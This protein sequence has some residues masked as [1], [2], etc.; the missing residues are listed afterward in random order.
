MNKKILLQVITYIEEHIFEEIT[1]EKLS[2]V[3]HY[4]QFY[5]A[6]L[7]KAAFRENISD[8]QKKRRLTIAAQKLL[9]T[10]MRIID[11]AILCG[12]Q[13]Q[14]AFT[15]SFKKYFDVTP[16]HYRKKKVPFYNLYKYPIT[17]QYI[18]KLP[19]A[20]KE[21]PYT[22]IHLQEFEI[23][24]LHYQGKNEKHEVARLYNLV[25]AALHFEV[26]Y[27]KIDG[28]YGLEYVGSGEYEKEG[29]EILVGVKKEY[30]QSTEIPIGE[31]LNKKVLEADYAVFELT[32]FI[33][34]IRSQVELIWL[35]MLQD[36][37]YCC[38]GNYCFEFYEQGF[39]PN[40]DGKGA[41][42]YLPVKR[43]QD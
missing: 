31:V 27:E 20:C 41:K 32:A 11:I 40:Q 2:E 38:L 13:S 1:L 6:K 16:Q 23:V 33:E 21:F 7:I 10:D 22:I 42:L 39:I 24:G 15:R 34:Q 17:D 12:Y 14:E 3:F 5:F 4:S 36:E 30:L 43:K 9:D 28:I 26:L 37:E 29:F 35:Q 18:K 19:N 25:S 8:Y